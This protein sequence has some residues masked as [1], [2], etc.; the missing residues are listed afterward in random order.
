MSEFIY[1]LNAVGYALG[2]LF[3]VFSLFALVMAAM[4]IYGVM[5]YMVSQRAREISLRMALGAERRDVLRMVLVRGGR[6]ILF[7]AVLGIGLAWLL[8]RLI[9]GLIYGV[10]P[11]DPVS[12]LGIP[13]VLGLIAFAANYIPAFRATRIDPMSAMRQD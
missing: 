5:S 6:L 1:D 10:S 12:F 9:A 7:G 8:S 11:T 13:A 2:T 4:G 3:T